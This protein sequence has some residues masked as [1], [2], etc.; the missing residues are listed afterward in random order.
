MEGQDLGSRGGAQE[1]GND[2]GLQSGADDQ[3]VEH[4]FGVTGGDAHSALARGNGNGFVAEE[5]LP[6]GGADVVGH[7]FGGGHEVHN[8]G[9]RRVQRS[10]ARDMRFDVAHPVGAK[11]AQPRNAVR[12]RTPLNVCQG[13][14]FVLCEGNDEF[15][16]LTVREVLLQAVDARKLPAALAQ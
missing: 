13:R 7:G 8:G 6:A 14:E 3:A 1:T 9:A 2:V 4:H 5:D 15:P 11:A 16:Q 12:D 10:D